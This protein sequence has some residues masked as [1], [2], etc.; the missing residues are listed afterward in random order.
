V[1]ELTVTEDVRVEATFATHFLLT[2]G[3]HGGGAGVVTSTPAGIDCGATCSAPFPVNMMV[4]RAQTPDPGSVGASWSGGGTCAD[5]ACTVAMTSPRAVT[6]RFLP[7]TCDVF[8]IDDTTTVAGWTER[9]ADWAIAAHG[10]QHGS[11]GG[12][13][14]K[15][16][17]SMTD[18]CARAMLSFGAGAP[19]DQAA[20]LVLR[21]TADDTYTV[22]EIAASS[23]SQEFDQVRLFDRPAGTLLAS[24]TGLALGRTPVLE[25]C[26]TGTQLRVRVDVE[27]DDVYDV[28]V[29]GTT[30]VVAAGVA[31]V[32]TAS[33]DDPT[34]A[35]D[36]CWGP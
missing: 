8:T 9:G 2:V 33:L 25:V 26:A 24:Q 3:R 36:F 13:I 17:S 27:G 16:A 19:A 11:V 12:T 23:G 14:T 22:G 29:A 6:A 34:R 28:T 4:A 7:D 10:L 1:C 21:L 20:G 15:D 32:R 35:E 5:V 31:G 18:G 30:A